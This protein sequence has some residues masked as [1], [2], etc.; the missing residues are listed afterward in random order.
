MRTVVLPLYASPN[1]LETGVEFT[2]LIFT[3]NGSA[4][5]EHKHA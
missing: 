1:T 3:I 5:G 2:V 4:L